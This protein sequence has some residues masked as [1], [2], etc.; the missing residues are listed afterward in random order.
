MTHKEHLLDLY[1]N[2]EKR[3][4]VL[5]RTLFSHTQ[6]QIRLLRAAAPLRDQR[7]R[8]D[9]LAADLRRDGFVVVKSRGEMMILKPGQSIR[10]AWELEFILQS[11][12][13]YKATAK[14]CTERYEQLELLV[15]GAADVEFEADLEAVPC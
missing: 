1:A 5:A 4:D 13:R 6:T 14:T 12:R 10:N 9:Q 11:V 8:L 2:G 3:V 15:D 7:T